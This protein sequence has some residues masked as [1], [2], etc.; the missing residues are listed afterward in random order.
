M[1]S[2]RTPRGEYIETDT[3]NKVARK[4]TLVGTQN[5]MLG[6]KTVIMQDAMIRGDLARTALTASSSSGSG[7]APA[8]NTA[9]A[10]GRYCFLSKGCC[11]RPPGRMYKGVFTYMPL[12]MGDH[13][14]VG[15]G[16]VVQAATIGS[17]VYIG[18]NTVIDEFAIVKDYVRILDGT[19]V[20]PNMVIP[21]FTIVAGQ[22]ARVVGEIPEGDHDQFELREL[23]KT[24]G[25]NPQPLH[26]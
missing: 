2:R 24:V 16:T 1:S 14:F 18:N 3:G 23:Y 25:N 9:I 8:N 7:A 17:H 6:G 5:I 11:L 12:R 4:A 26:V 21:S 19:V 13:V 10:I 22:P 20:P 15:E